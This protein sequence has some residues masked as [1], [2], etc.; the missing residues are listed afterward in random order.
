MRTSEKIEAQAWVDQFVTWYNTVHRHS[1]IRF[2]TPDD[3]HYGREP[4]ILANRHRLYQKAR[5]RRPDRW[6]K[7][8]RN[9]IAVKDVCLNP[10]KEKQ[11][12]HASPQQ[13][14]A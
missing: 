3:R 11:G 12:S 9:W 10:E 4:A 2:V 5:Q 8:T 13:K 6:T 14:A 7:Q 1:A